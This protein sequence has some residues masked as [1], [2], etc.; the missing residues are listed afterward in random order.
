MLELS[1]RGATKRAALL[2]CAE[3]VVMSTV[4][5]PR[6]EAYCTSAVPIWTQRTEREREREVERVE[7]EC[8][9]VCE[10]ERE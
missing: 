6:V 1:N 3:A 8:V 2:S 10:R 4:T 7:R 9:C 5:V